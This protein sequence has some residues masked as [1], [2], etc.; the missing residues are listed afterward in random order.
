MK[1]ADDLGHKEAQ[2]CLSYMRIFSKN[3]TIQE[4][5]VKG[6]ARLKSDTE[7]VFYVCSSRITLKARISKLTLKNPDYLCVPL[8]CKSKQEVFELH[9]NSPEKNVYQQCERCIADIE[10]AYAGSDYFNNTIYLLYDD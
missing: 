8:F 10:V 9:I 7:G 4:E 2:Y 6:L 3:E 5:G 1:I